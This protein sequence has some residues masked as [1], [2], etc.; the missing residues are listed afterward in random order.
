MFFRLRLR[1]SLQNT[2]E[3]PN[4]DSLTHPGTKTGGLSAL[5]YIGT[6]FP[7]LGFVNVYPFVFSFMAD[8][9]QYLATLALI[10]FVVALVFRAA[11]AAVETPR[12]TYIAS[13]LIG[14]VV[15]VFA[16][17]TWQ[18]ISVYESAKTVYQDNLDKN[19]QAWMAD[20]NLGQILAENGEYEAAIGHYRKSIKIRPRNEEA[21][22]NLGNALRAQ[23]KFDEAIKSIQKAIQLEPNHTNAHYHLGLVYHIKEDFARAI[24]HYRTA[25]ELNP[26]FATAHY[27]LA[28]ALKEEGHF[29]AAVRHCRRAVEIDPQY[30][31]ARKGLA[32]LLKDQGSLEEAFKHWSDYEKLQQ[33][34]QR[35]GPNEP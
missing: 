5:I 16:A 3:L 34:Q 1:L 27:N 30:A 31:R 20:Q 11:L 6:L 19:P 24:R 32:L 25:L 29:E 2:A 18:R 9:F 8:H 15:V 4:P 12:S 14:V 26:R 23:G 33:M 35:R 10:A 7:A 21:Y 13:T 22:N 28:V 17:V